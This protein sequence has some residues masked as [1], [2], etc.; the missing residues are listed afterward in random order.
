MKMIRYVSSVTILVVLMLVFCF[1]AAAALAKEIQQSRQLPQLLADTDNTTLGSQTSPDQNS[2]ITLTTDYPNISAFATDSFA[3]NINL[4]YVGDVQRVFDLN[5]AMPS[6]WQVTFQPQDQ[7]GTYVSSIPID[8]S[9]SGMTKTI[10][11]TATPTASPSPEPGDYKILFQA[12]SD[13]ISGSIELTARIIPE[14]KLQVESVNQLS[15]TTALSGKDNI[16][17]IKLTNSGP[18]VL[19]SVSFNSTNPAG[20]QIKFAPDKLDT[21]TA[22]DSKTVDV[23]I[24]PSGEDQIR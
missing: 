11:L 20:W 2:N 5:A 7:T 21:L 16:F 23:D 9:Y 14:Y 22:S 3:Y 13:N 12:V 6:G 17:S 24:K 8:S 1:P 15:N 10:I 18:S 19:N 4:D